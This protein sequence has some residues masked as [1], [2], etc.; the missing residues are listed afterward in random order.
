MTVLK[1]VQIVS[2][3][4][5]ATCAKTYSRFHSGSYVPKGD[6]FSEVTFVS[7]RPFKVYG[8]SNL[9]RHVP[10]IHRIYRMNERWEQRDKKHP[11]NNRKDLEVIIRA[12]IDRLEKES[13]DGEI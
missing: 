8:S 4:L 1:R 6:I 11:A 10:E 7:N 2:T 13:K 3:V 9:Y 12:H 5:T